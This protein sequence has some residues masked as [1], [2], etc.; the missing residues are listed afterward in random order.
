MGVS[1]TFVRWIEGQRERRDR[2]GELARYLAELPA[3]RNPTCRA[4]LA[5]WVREGRYERAH[6]EAV[7]A[8]W[9]G[10]L[11]ARS[12]LPVAPPRPPAVPLAVVPRPPPSLRL[13]PVR[14]GILIRFPGHPGGQGPGAA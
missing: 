4:E 6:V 11:G 14:G 9:R 12:D 5:S 1:L 13:V 3:R 7:G 2:V 8:A 10:F